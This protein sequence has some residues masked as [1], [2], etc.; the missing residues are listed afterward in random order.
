MSPRTISISDYWPDDCAKLQHCYTG[1]RGRPVAK[2]RQRP[3]NI[4]GTSIFNL[5]PQHKYLGKRRRVY[6]NALTSVGCFVC[7]TL[8]T[9]RGV[10]PREQS[11]ISRTNIP[12]ARNRW[13]RSALAMTVAKTVIAQ[14]KHGV[15]CGGGVR[16]EVVLQRRNI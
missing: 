1:C 12:T 10:D 4:A 15:S 2:R 7:F 6:F 9:V 16:V 14:W 11:P 13:E 3:A 5:R 8:F